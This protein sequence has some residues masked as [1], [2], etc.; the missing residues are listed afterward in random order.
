MATV[1]SEWVTKKFYNLLSSVIFSVP[2]STKNAQ[3]LQQTE[4]VIFF[5]WW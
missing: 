1:S 2:E 3:A 5:F 4:A